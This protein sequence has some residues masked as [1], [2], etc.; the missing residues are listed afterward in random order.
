MRASL[1]HVRRIAVG[2]LICLCAFPAYACS[3]GTGLWEKD[4]AQ[5]IRSNSQVFIAR[6]ISF[7]EVP[8]AAG[9]DYYI[10]QMQ[11][12]MLDVI[13]GRPE[14]LGTLSEQNPGHVRPGRP[15]G[16]VC[17]PFL[18]GD[19]NV[20][21]TAIVFAERDVRAGRFALWAAPFS[22]IVD[23]DN[24]EIDEMLQQIRKLAQESN[25]Q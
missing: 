20:G 3:I 14:T 5:A 18:T 12:V 17:G 4:F 6:L 21:K 19:Y 25:T 10:N 7:D 22:R 24:P 15:P 8:P 11:Y 16:P 9:H 1:R 13:K 23:L 2:L